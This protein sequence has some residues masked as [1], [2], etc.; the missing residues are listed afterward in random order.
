MVTFAILAIVVGF[1]VVFANVWGEAKWYSQI[2]ASKVFWTQW[3]L[4]TLLGVVGAFVV[5]LVLFVNIKIARGRVK[6]IKPIKEPSFF[7]KFFDDHRLVSLVLLPLIV[8]AFFG[9]SLGTQWRTYVLWLHRTSFGTVDAEFGHDVSF[10][11]FTLPL[12]HS[13]L[14][15]ALLLLVVAALGAVIGHYAYGGFGISGN[16]EL[17]KRARNHIAVLGGLAIVLLGLFFWIS[18]YDLLLG[19][20]AK[21]SGASYTDVKVEIPGYLILAISAFI[22]A[23]LFVATTMMGR[24]R[25]SVVGL[26]TLLVVSLV[27]NWA[28]PSLA[29]QF[30]VNPNAVEKESEYIQ[31]NINATLKAYDLE[32]VENINYFD[33]NGASDEGNE[34]ADEKTVQESSFSFDADQQEEMATQIRLLDPHVVSQTFKQQDA[35]KAFYSFP[36]YLSVDRYNI[37]GKDQDTV[38]GVRELNLDGLKND[39]RNW[40][41]DH[42]VYTHGYGVVAAYGNTIDA[43]GHPK[44]FQQGIPTTGLLGDYEPRVYFGLTSPDYSVVGAPKGSE[45][46]ELDYED[47]SQG[48]KT[49]YQGDGGPSI[50]DSWNRLMYAIKFGSYELYFSDRVTEE[51]QIL[52]DRD[53]RERVRKV[54]PYLTLDSEVYPAVVDMDGDDSTKKR[55][56]WIIDGY[57]TSNNFPYSARS[58]MSE[59][60]RDSS[61]D[62]VGSSVYSE[63]EVNY[64]RNSVKAV[65][66]AYDGSVKLYTWDDADPILKAWDKVFPGMLLSVEDMSA[67]LL[68]HIRY[69]SDLFKVQRSVL[70]KYH[71]QDSEGFYRGAGFW[72]VSP[73]PE[74]TT[75]DNQQ[76]QHP[77]YMTLQMPGQDTAEFS[78][79]SGFVPAGNDGTVQMTGFLAVDSNAGH[80]AGKVREGYGKLRLLHMPTD[81]AMPGA[82]QANSDFNNSTHTKELK[83]MEINGTTKVIRGNLLTLPVDGGMLYVQPVY[84]QAQSGTKMPKLQYVFTGFA[85]TQGSSASVGFAASLSDSLK[86]M[87]E[88]VKAKMNSQSGGESKKDDSDSGSG[89]TQSTQGASETPSESTQTTGNNEALTKALENAQ[90]AL[91]ASEKARQSGDWSAYGEAQKALEQAVND[92]VTAQNK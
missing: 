9:G 7:R 58:T 88:Q 26:S 60:T 35:L 28:Y 63:E 23:V 54:A 27:V 20:N 86:M 16:V 34:E 12:L 76:R 22:L 2:K 48:V 51:S 40:I 73:E 19:N 56:V 8:G 47:A 32:D 72:S 45:D 82:M 79:S 69:P 21:F 62:E 30:V 24:W 3:G 64:V 17:T 44:Y 31:R 43:E 78:L 13:L 55:L 90:K 77:Y 67:D 38:I 42:T 84:M 91:E 50:G 37:D 81:K 83:E 25:L 65:V 66:D 5:A 6:N 14:S 33:A 39:Q 15:F 1:F 59:V 75:S 46:K 41:N 68:S 4:G 92:A 61:T 49:T 18:R 70:A 80:T 29:Q 36:N 53:P 11:V 85:N 89:S 57:T 52:F 74:S 71:V 87:S 10:Y